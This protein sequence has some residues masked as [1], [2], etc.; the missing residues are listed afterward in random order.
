[1]K[2]RGEMKLA[3]EHDGVVAFVELMKQLSQEIEGAARA[4]DRDRVRAMADRHRATFAQ[5]RE[6][7]RESRKTTRS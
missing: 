6:I 7:M 1:M 3:T 4:K 5:L 2:K